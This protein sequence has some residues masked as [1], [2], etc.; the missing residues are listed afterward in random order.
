MKSRFMGASLFLALLFTFLVAFAP[1][2]IPRAS[3]GSNGSGW[4]ADSLVYNGSSTNEVDPSISTDSLGNLYIAYVHW[5]PEVSHW[6]LLVSKSTDEGKTWSYATGVS[7]TDA[8]Y[9]YPCLAIATEGQNQVMVA[10]ELSVGGIGVLKYI[11]GQTALQMITLSANAHHPSLTFDTT[12]PVYAYLTY[13]L[14]QTEFGLGWDIHFTR[15]TDYSGNWTSWETSY[16]IVGEG[17][18]STNNMPSIAYG[19]GGNLYIAYERWNPTDSRWYIHLMR[20]NDNGATGAWTAEPGREISDPDTANK[21]V[22]KVAASH[23]LPS[24]VMV[25]YEY[26]TAPYGIDVD[27]AWSA[28][29]GSDWSAGI[30][31]NNTAD[32]RNPAIAVDNSD[33]FHVT[34]WRKEDAGSRING[35][36]YQRAYYSAP[37]SWTAPEQVIDSDGWAHEFHNTPTI[38]AQQRGGTFYPVIAWTDARGTTLDV[39]YTTP[40]ATY[41]ITSNPTS[42]GELPTVQ[43]DSVTYTTPTSFN[44]VAGT[45]HTIDVQ[46]PQA[47]EGV[48]Y[49]FAN[50]SD[51]G[52]QHHQI[53]AYTMDATVTASFIKQYELNVSTEPIGLS[54]QPSIS[55]AGPWHN[56][57]TVVNITA[58]LAT[59]G[60]YLDNWT[61]DGSSQGPDETIS[62]VMNTPHNIV[63]NYQPDITPPVISDLQ[64]N[65]P[66]QEIAAQ[67]EVT[68][69]VVAKDNQ[70]GVT[71]VTL[72]YRTSTDNMTWSQWIDNPMPN[73]ARYAYAFNITGFDAGTYLQYKVTATDNANNL[74]TL[75]VIQY[76][77]YSTIPEYAHWMTVLLLLLAS[78]T[79]L[80]MTRAHKHKKDFIS[81]PL[82]GTRHQ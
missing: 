8:D 53:S 14:N 55:P 15:S 12:M 60:Y 17:D 22:P 63:A 24:T 25:V 4:I 38:S 79:S 43:V 82:S 50:W 47:G 59:S 54:P 46:S 18:S 57:G 56:S 58:Q 39:Y 1:V 81:R 13:E 21:R 70:T 26:Y 5:F 30:L 61:V 75:P 72:S 11:G 27:Y 62:I 51:L 31:T 69:Q 16:P 7:S 28:N 74:A 42:T 19:Q 78:L 9:A 2:T 29:G 23:S 73:I 41:T 44:W 20:N 35:I 65:P 33:Y 52:S 80:T 67:Q 3:A 6:G 45:N 10:F 66:G 40:G 37:T 71:N 76:F 64:Q 48:K 49:L 36:C 32:E 68:V 34:Y 77:R